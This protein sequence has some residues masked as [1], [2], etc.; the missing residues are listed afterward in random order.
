MGEVYRAS[1]P[2]LKRDV[3]IKVIAEAFAKDAE[4][5]HRFKLEAQA[6]GRLNHPNVLAIYDAGVDEGSPYL[7]SE[8]LDGES[9][10]SRL[11]AG[12]LSPQRALD[13]ARQ[14]ARGLAA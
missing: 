2:R 7:A 8:L 3:A 11:R 1:D 4:L 13:Y 10:R 5:V 6:V 14:I 12:K 9:L